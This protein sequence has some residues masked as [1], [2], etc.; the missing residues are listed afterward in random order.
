MAGGGGGGDPL[1]VEENTPA[2]TIIGFVNPQNDHGTN[3]L[4]LTILSGDPYGTFMIS[5]L[6]GLL[7]VAL[8]DGA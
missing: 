7:R 1:L 6:N 4:S 5:E 8:A 2:G 3:P